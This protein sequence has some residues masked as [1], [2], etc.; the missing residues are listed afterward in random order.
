MLS[1]MKKDFALTKDKFKLFASVKSTPTNYEYLK[2]SRIYD[3]V[4]YNYDIVSE[5]L[6]KRETSYMIPVVGY[7]LPTN[8]TKL[9]NAGRPYRAGYTSGVHE[10]WD[11][12]A[13]LYTPVVAID[14]GEVVY[15]KTDFDKTDF[16]NLVLGEHVS[17]EDKMNNLDILRG[18]QV[19]I[20]TMK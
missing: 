7:E 1:K 16:Q 15:T 18:N 6:E 13:P 20:K 2:K 14:D 3:E 11:I 10:G 9:P 12:N 5:I 8:A 17:E 4:A 19:W